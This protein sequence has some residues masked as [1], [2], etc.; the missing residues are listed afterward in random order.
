MGGKPARHAA[1]RALSASLDSPIELILHRARELSGRNAC[2]D[3]IDA[4]ARAA[5]VRP[6]TGSSHLY[7]SW[8]EAAEMGAAGVTFGN[9]TAT[10]PDLTMLD[11]GA[12]E[13]EI[14]R[15]SR[16]LEDHLPAEARLSALAYPFGVHDANT[17]EAVASCGIGATLAIGGRNEFGNPVQL[18]RTPA[19]Q[20]SVARLFA[21]LEIVEP[22]KASLRR[23]FRHLAHI[24]LVRREHWRSSSAERHVPGAPQ[25]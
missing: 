14:L 23:L 25:V 17:S 16:S 5:G 13:K 6:P 12:Q 20:A 8:P 7:L 3:L 18:A 19:G 15:A 21:D 9:H 2:R 24:P 10:H 1:A 4:V 11:V 22:A